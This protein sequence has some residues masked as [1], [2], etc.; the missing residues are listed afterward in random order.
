MSQAGIN[1]MKAQME[2]Y[3][4]KVKAAISNG[5][6]G[7]A[8]FK[9]VTGS[10]PA[11]GSIVYDA[12]T[13]LGFNATTHYAYSLGIQLSIN[14]PAV[15]SNPPVIGAEA[16]LRYEIAADGKVTLRNNNAS[17]ITYYA[18]YTLPVKR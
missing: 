4:A 8:T 13:E 3:F 5:G 2:A 11:N 12:P 9:Y 10:I 18:R 6:G 15:S 17:A 1:Y 7:G 16:V 14:D